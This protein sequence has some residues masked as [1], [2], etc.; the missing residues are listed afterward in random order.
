[1]HRAVGVLVGLVV[2]TAAACGTATPMGIEGFATDEV[3]LDG[4]EWAVAVADSEPLRR[5]G[6]MGI[7]ELGGLDGM[8]FVFPSD[9]E[10]G[11][12]MRDTPMALDI[13]FFDAAGR[14]VDAFTMDPCRGPPCPV[15]RSSAPY[16]YALE[17]PRGRLASVGA[18]SVLTVGS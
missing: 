1:M 14:F 4:R 12:W 5:R 15:Y 13:A 16:R 17:A 9:T 3:T 10:T 18:D 11:F 8:V 7:T 2:L 6:L